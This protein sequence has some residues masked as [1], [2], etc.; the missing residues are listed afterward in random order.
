MAAIS[1]RIHA[2]NTPSHQ[3]AVRGSNEPR[4]DYS[5]AMEHKTMRT[6][7]AAAIETK[8]TLIPALEYLHVCLSGKA[9]LALSLAV[10]S[11]TIVATSWSETAGAGVVGF[12]QQRCPFLGA[13]GEQ[14]FV[15]RGGDALAAPGCPHEDLADGEGVRLAGVR[16]RTGFAGTAVSS[17]R[18]SR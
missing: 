5:A 2:R 9:S 4:F 6:R 17:G 13:A 16:S 15:E 12:D 18:S 3:F 11:S 10:I 7:V 14:L 1:T 8:Y